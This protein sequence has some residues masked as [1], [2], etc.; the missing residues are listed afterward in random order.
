MKK[1]HSKSIAY[2]SLGLI[3]F[4][5]TAYLA[6]IQTNHKAAPANTDAESFDATPSLPDI[7]QAPTHTKTFV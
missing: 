2:F 5:C 6:T 7:H 4:F 1:E 3:V